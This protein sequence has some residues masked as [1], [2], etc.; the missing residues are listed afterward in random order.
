MP[1]KWLVATVLISC[2]YF[3]NFQSERCR[4]WDLPQCDLS[5]C[6][7][8]GVS[9]IQFQKISIFSY[10][11][12]K[13]CKWVNG[14]FK[15]SDRD[16]L[17]NWIHFKL[18]RKLKIGPKFKPLDFFETKKC[19]SSHR[20]PHLVGHLASRLGPLFQGLVSAKLF[21]KSV[22]RVC[23]RLGGYRTKPASQI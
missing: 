18:F 5:R 22:G 4:K 8:P 3:K 1:K 21:Q 19:I 20:A 12:W 15:S 6:D 14:E 11:R 13:S 23:R 16:A 10:F 9:M 17:Q 2:V 7:W